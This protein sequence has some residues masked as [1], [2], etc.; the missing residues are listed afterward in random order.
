MQCA[1][2][3]VSVYLKSIKGCSNSR[4]VSSYLRRHWLQEAEEGEGGSERAVN[5]A[6]LAGVSGQNSVAARQRAFS[7]PRAPCPHLLYHQQ[8]NQ[9]Q[10]QNP[11]RRHPPP[12][13]HS[14]AFFDAPSPVSP[15]FSALHSPPPQT[16][17][18]PLP[19]SPIS[20][21]D[22]YRAI[23]DLPLGA[24]VPSS[25]TLVILLFCL[26]FEP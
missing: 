4:R 15:K 2:L 10:Q 16:P 22:K 24:F 21:K 20:I 5:E 3:P 7:D 18:P 13:R 1:A 14:V 11:L 23:F 25:L 19:I 17:S 9:H 6:A 12:A 8:H 26:I